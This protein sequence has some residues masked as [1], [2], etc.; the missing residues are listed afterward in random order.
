[1]KTRAQDLQ[2]LDSD[3]ATLREKLKDAKPRDKERIQAR[4]TGLDT[5]ARR[6]ITERHDA[7]DAQQAQQQQAQAAAHARQEAA[8]RQRLRSAWPGD[9]QSFDAAYPKLLE[10][11]RINA[12]LAGAD[13]PPAIVPTVRM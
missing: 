2:Q 1:M 8:Q 13:A 12:A 6:L 4:I 11:Y 3:I 5:T 10:E 9:D 7:N